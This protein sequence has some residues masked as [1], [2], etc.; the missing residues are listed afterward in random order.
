[1]FMY[2]HV[3]AMIKE[4]MNLNENKEEYMRGYDGGNGRGKYN[5]N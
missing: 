5:Q 3:I 1:M 2:M 4:D